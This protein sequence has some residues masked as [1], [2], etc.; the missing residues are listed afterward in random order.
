MTS[1]ELGLGGSVVVDL[2]KSLPGG[3]KY[4]LYFDNFL[5]SLRLLDHL[6]ELNIGAT[7]VTNAH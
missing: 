4:S 2:V 6:T 3:P 1:Q 5:T 7:R